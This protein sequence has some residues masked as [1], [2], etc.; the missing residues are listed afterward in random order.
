ML[1]S[2]FVYGTLKRGECR[3]SLWPC[4]PVSIQVGWTR[5]MLF[6]RH[7]Y[8]AMQAGEDRVRGEFWSFTD[9]QMPQVMRVLDQIEG[10]NQ[11]GFDD[12]YRR[13]RVEVY[14]TDDQPLGTAFGYH[15]AADP[16][17]D[18]FTRVVPAEPDAW[19]QWP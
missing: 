3:E 5:G 18:G 19:I 9:E 2:V 4:I 6:H 1:T 10:T 13:V 7:D 11:P 15:Y 17:A 8:P 12:L 14:A 16:L